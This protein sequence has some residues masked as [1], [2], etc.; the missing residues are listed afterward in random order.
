MGTPKGLGIVAR[1]A[2]GQR[3]RAPI[4]WAGWGHTGSRDSGPQYEKGPKGLRAGRRPLTPGDGLGT[5]KV[6]GLWGISRR[7]GPWG[8]EGCEALAYLNPD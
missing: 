8:R 6:Q 3:G 7:R 2:R 5:C 4:P 1:V